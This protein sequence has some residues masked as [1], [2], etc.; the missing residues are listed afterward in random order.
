MPIT[1][2]IETELRGTAFYPLLNKPDKWGKYKID[3]VLSG[4]Q[5]EKAKEMGLALQQPKPGSAQ[6]GTFVTIRV[7]VEDAKRGKLDKVPASMADG[8]PV[9]DLIG[10][11][12]DVTV[13]FAAGPYMQKGKFG[14]Y[15][16]LQSVVVNTLIKYTPKAA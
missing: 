12:S 6:T 8:S 11:G 10:N 15:S 9:T 1:T 3:L 2:R 5:L 13:K 4:D 16:I 7:P 14:V